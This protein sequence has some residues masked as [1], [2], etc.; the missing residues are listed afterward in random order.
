[1]TLQR[2]KIM[3]LAHIYHIYIVE[4]DYFGGLDDLTKYKPLYYYL[5][6]KNC[7]YLK[8]FS[9]ILPYL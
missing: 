4:D 6:F 2:K 1:M 5:E 8:S 7:L 9:K 3:E